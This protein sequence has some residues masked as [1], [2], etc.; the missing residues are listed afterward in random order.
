[1]IKRII[2]L[3]IILAVLF[4]FTAC[5]NSS[6]TSSSGSSSIDATAESPSDEQSDSSAVDNSTSQAVSDEAQDDSSSQ[7]DDDS[8]EDDTSETDDSDTST[9]QTST[10]TNTQPAFAITKQPVNT[11]VATGAPLNLSVTASG[12]GTLTYQWYAS[13]TNDYQGILMTDKTDSTISLFTNNPF[14][15][16]Y[17]CVVTQKS[18]GQTLTTKIITASA[19]G[20]PI[21]GSSEPAPVPAPLSDVPEISTNL[22]NVTYVE[23]AT[24]TALNVVVNVPSG[25]GTLSYQWFIGTPPTGTEL[26]GETSN[27][28][29]PTLG[30][31]NTS[32]T[33]YCVITNTLTNG[34][35]HT[36][37]STAAIVSVVASD[38]PIITTQPVDASYPVGATPTA[39]NVVV[40][41]PSGNGTLSYQWFRGT[42]SSGT[43]LV[44]AIS[45]TYTP[46]LGGVNTSETYYCVITNTVNG[47]THT[48]TSNAATIDVIDRSYY[49]WVKGVEVKATNATD[50]LNDGGKVSFD[51]TTNTLTLNESI[52]YDGQDSAIRSILTETLTIRTPNSGTSIISNGKYPDGNS[53]SAINIFDDLIID[54]TG[55]LEV[56]IAPAADGA[57]GAD[58]TDSVNKH[59][60]NGGD[61]AINGGTTI[62]VSGNL[63]ITNDSEVLVTGGAGGDGGEGGRHFYT[64]PTGDGTGKGGNGGNGSSGGLAIDVAGTLTIAENA[65]VTANGGSGG[66][67]GI[68]GGSGGY[69]VTG[70]GGDGGNGNHAISA[71][72]VIVS[73]DAELTATG[74]KGGTGGALPQEGAGSGEPGTG[75]NG[76]IGIRI[77]RASS[78]LTIQ[79]TAKVV[80]N[81]GNGG[82][83]GENIASYSY[84]NGGDGGNG[85]DGLSG[86]LNKSATATL[87]E[88]GGDGGDG[89]T[90]GDSRN[91]SRSGANGG[92]GGAGGNGVTQGGDGGD[93]GDGGLA[94]N[95][96]N[97]G[98]GGA[99]GAGGM[100]SDGNGG[101]GGDGGDGGSAT[102]GGS[103][104]INGGAGGAGGD[105]G[106]GKLSGGAG[107]AGGI[108]GN[109]KS[110]GDGGAGGNG[111]HGGASTDGAGGAGGKGGN[112]GVIDGTNSF[113][114]GANGGNGGNGGNGKL[115]GAGGA[116]GTG[117]M[118]GGNSSADNGVNGSN[119]NP[120]ATI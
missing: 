105:G 120:G 55:T 104:Q 41:V 114:D 43:E 77:T 57:D 14:T 50:V 63:T 13:L 5:A 99:G 1:M 106:S 45:N 84:R 44:G 38:A 2:Y 75:G 95:S 96:N 35:T 23:G 81:G 86:L 49:I 19:V 42:P 8:D 48:A 21:G 52:I 24:P 93:G 27:T 59:G 4:S 18:T 15:Q 80:I 87:T 109:G 53:Y 26:V 102:V 107:G 11:S 116:G 92:A 90:G 32:E 36:A 60:A 39:L 119:G 70:S 16:Y 79:N 47:I 34:T 98:N 12:S 94:S 101:N 7:S 76:G 103:G 108:G 46:I 17:Y 69:T 29:T 31:A 115:G 113:S 51:A 110:S 58:G 28:Y 71:L 40:N 118:G 83:G 89:G 68:G 111:G 56:G 72:E 85:G 78:A 10:S 25:N 65:K 117:S 37:T 62:Y 30:A 66:S 54:A 67:G 61:A 112:A 6:C 33:Y 3:I 82:K 91:S 22:S 9:T 97:G 100:A 64:G 73:Q 20:E 74:G 88:K